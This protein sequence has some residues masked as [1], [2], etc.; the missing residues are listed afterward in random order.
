MIVDSK[1]RKIWKEAVLKYI[2]IISRVLLR[3]KKISQGTCCN[4]LPLG[5]KLNPDL[6]KTNQQHRTLTLEFQQLWIT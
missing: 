5:K 6:Y 4:S 2:M 3:F 1:I